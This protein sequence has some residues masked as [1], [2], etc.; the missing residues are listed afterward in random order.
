MIAVVLLV[1]LTTRISERDAPTFLFGNDAEL[2]L[3]V[4]F[5][6]T[7]FHTLHEYISMQDFCQVIVSSAG[8]LFSAIDDIQRLCALLFLSCW[9]LGSFS[10]PSKQFGHTLYSVQPQNL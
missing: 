3:L 5:L 1:L 6:V 10:M 4:F 7:G 9:H 8:V 2:L